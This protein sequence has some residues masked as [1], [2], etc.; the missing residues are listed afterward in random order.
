LLLPCCWNLIASIYGIATSSSYSIVV[1]SSVVCR[2]AVARKKRSLFSANAA[3]QRHN[4]A[5]VLVDGH[6]EGVVA[7]TAGRRVSGNARE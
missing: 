5:F 4:F 7:V 1:Q 2:R 3:Q 6:F